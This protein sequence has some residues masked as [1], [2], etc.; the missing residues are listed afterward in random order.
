MVTGGW[1]VS[2]HA[3]GVRQGK[4]CMGQGPTTGMIIIQVIIF[5]LQSQKLEIDECFFK[6]NCTEATCLHCQLLVNTCSVQYSVVC[7]Y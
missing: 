5:H 4:S 1:S 2:Q 6:S 3:M 7:S